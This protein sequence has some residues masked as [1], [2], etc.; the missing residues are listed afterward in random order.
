MKIDYYA[1]T[2]TY[3]KTLHPNITNGNVLDYGSNYGMFL[4][5]SNGKF[6][7]FNYTGIDVD[8][9]AL[10]DG[11]KL[12]PNAVFIKSQQFNEI[13]NPNGHLLRPEIGLYNTIISYSVVTHT[14][15]EDF[16][17]T[18]SWLYEHLL[19]G[20]KLLITY[21]DV[22]HPTT[23]QYFYNKR[24]KDFGQCDLITTESYTYL[25]DNLI[26]SHPVIGQFLLLFWNNTFLIENVLY[27]YEEWKLHEN[28]PAENCF[29][30]CIEITKK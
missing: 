16:V 27:Q 8:S 26:Q 4:D 10:D 11:R 1:D 3:F 17:D 28:I 22:N 20:G 18:L 12:F 14:S 6:S 9:V 19:P 7:E 25:N 30:S 29:Q 23:N 5:S 24:V 13:Y 21:L 2:F 15:K